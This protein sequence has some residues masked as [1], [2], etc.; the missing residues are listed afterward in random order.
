MENPEVAQVFDEV[1]DI[2]DIQGEKLFRIRAY[3]NA[4]RIIRDLSVPLAQSWK[5]WSRGRGNGATTSSP[6]QTIPNE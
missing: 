2:L 3:R 5:R 4:A 1:A 6:S